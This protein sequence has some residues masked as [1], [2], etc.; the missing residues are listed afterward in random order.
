MTNSAET[1]A[2]FAAFAWGPEHHGVLSASPVGQWTALDARI[3]KDYAADSVAN[4]SRLQ[5]SGALDKLSGALQ[6]VSRLRLAHDRMVQEAV[7]HPM[8]AG[9]SA[10]FVATPVLADF[11]G[12][13]LQARAALDRLAAC[14]SRMLGQQPASYRSI[15]GTLKTLVKKRAECADLLAIRTAARPWAD[16]FLA[17]KDS[18]EA[19]RD[20]ISHK[21]SLQEGIETV[22]AR[23]YGNDRVLLLDCEVRLLGA[24]ALTP[25]LLTARA[26]AQY[27]PYVVLN[28]LAAVLGEK[29]LVLGAYLPEWPIHVVARSSF[30]LDVPDGTLTHPDGR[31]LRVLRRT[32]PGSVDLET[33]FFRYAMW[34]AAIPITRSTPSA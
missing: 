5:M 17:A 16:E 34:D 13:M 19:L 20:L 26:T 15:E 21:F 10:A 14:L 8:A 23:H 30:Q 3:A 29:E 25:I 18:S 31:I 33:R 6:Q 12:L 32:K 4:A 11:E 24:H 28:S 7:A 22:F 2:T 1:Q 27:L 9:D